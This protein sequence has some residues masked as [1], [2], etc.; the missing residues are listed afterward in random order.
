MSRLLEKPTKKIIVLV[1]SGRDVSPISFLESQALLDEA[2][3]LTCM[4]YVD[5]SF[6]IDGL[7]EPRW[8]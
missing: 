4:A 1:D 5:H 2:A 7:F 8:H 6:L 3:V